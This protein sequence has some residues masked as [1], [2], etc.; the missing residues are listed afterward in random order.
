MIDIINGYSFKRNEKN[1]VLYAATQLAGVLCVAPHELKEHYFYCVLD[2]CLSE[3]EIHTEEIINNEIELF[4]PVYNA[5][6]LIDSLIRE[7]FKIDEFQSKNVIDKML[8]TQRIVSECFDLKNGFQDYKDPIRKQDLPFVKPIG[9][10][11]SKHD[12]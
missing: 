6:S 10:S 7:G 1:T 5:K 3:G 9:E 8:E 11:I 2:Q 12:D 4:L